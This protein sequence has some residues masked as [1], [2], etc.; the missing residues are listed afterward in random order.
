MPFLCNR[1]QR[2]KIG[3]S[4]SD[5]IA[6]TTGV[7]QGSVLGPTLFLLDIN[8]FADCFADLDCTV[9]L[10]ADDAKI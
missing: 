2:V 6:I 10:Y 9:K 8:D 3:N 1:F 4:L 7:P 5:F